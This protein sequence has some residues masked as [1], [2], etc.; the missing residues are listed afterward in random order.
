M[1]PGPGRDFFV[2]CVE[3]SYEDACDGGDGGAD[4]A[5]YGSGE[6]EDEE[7]EVA[8]P[9]WPVLEKVSRVRLDWIEEGGKLQE[10][11]LD[12]QKAGERG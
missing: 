5:C 12:R 1:P 7:G 4:Y 11:H 6:A 10:D 3:F 9:E 8:F 2:G